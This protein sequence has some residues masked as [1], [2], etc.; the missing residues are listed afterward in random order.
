M[1]SIICCIAKNLAI[2]RKNQLLWHI[3]DDLKH[4]KKI[5]TGH[6]V[7]MGQ[8]TYESMGKPLPNRT[9]IVL[10]QDPNFKAEGCIVCS[11]IPE[12]IEA[13][14]S[15][16]NVILSDSEESKAPQTPEFFIIGGGSIYKQ[17]L[18]LADKLYLTIVEDAPQDADT[19]FPD[20]TELFKTIVSDEPH[21]SDGLKY[22]FV[23][24]VK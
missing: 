17:F 7:I 12:A 10:T 15:A 8:K 11:S 6:P 1:I 19:F 22:R 9:N 14:K 2:G 13:A 4:F 5:T 23:E 20:Y 24:I 18:P 16:P 21:E 3:S